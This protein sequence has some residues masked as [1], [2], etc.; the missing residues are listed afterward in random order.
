MVYY[1][2]IF[3]FVHK[4]TVPAYTLRDFDRKLL[5]TTLSAILLSSSRDYH[6]VL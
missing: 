4:D 1:T 6:V 5:A 3:A 2:I